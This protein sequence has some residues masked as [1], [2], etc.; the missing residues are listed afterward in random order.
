MVIECDSVIECSD[1][2]IETKG[3]LFCLS[4]E[5]EMKNESNLLDLAIQ[6]VYKLW[7]GTKGEDER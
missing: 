7:C 2:E 4:S 3:S 1:Y 5:L 6:A